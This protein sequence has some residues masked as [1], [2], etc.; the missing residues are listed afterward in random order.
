MRP[1]FPGRFTVQTDAPFVVFLIGMRINR[2][3]AIHRWAPF[4]LAMPRML[5]YLAGHPE[6]GYLGGETFVYWRGVGYLQ[7]WRSFED[8]ERFAAD[9]GAPHLE[10]WRR[11]VKQTESDHTFGF[12]HETYTIEPGRWECVYGSM[13]RFGLAQ[14]TQHVPA[15]GR[16]DS[17]R[18]RLSGAPAN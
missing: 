15:T 14:V 1:V 10:A 4:I 16:R 6:K 17:A 3:W 12:W 18:L 7:Y 8:L 2:L 13:P 9:R 11:L 5:H